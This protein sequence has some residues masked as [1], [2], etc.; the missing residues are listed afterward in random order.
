M[1]KV[2]SCFVLLS[3]VLTA[4]PSDNAAFQK[5][6]RGEYAKSYPLLL[7][8]SQKN[9][10]EALY[11]LA[12][13]KLYGYGERK[14]LAKGL[15]YMHLAADKNNLRAQMYLGAYYLN[16]KNNLKEAL[17]WLKKAANQGDASAQLFTG[18]CYLYGLD[19]KKNTDV[20]RK[21]FIMA[22]KNDVAMA[23]YELGQIFL[24]SRYARDRKMGRI[25][26][27]KARENNF[28]G[29][30]IVSHQEDNDADKNSS[31]QT[32][33]KLLSEAGIAI[34]N[35]KRLASTGNEK[36]EMPVYKPLSKSQ[37]IKPN[38][39]LITLNNFPIQPV[40]VQ[41]NKIAYL[42]HSLRINT[43]NVKD[44]LP[45]P[46][47]YNQ[48]QLR[49]LIREVNFGH[50]PAM[51]KLGLI[52][53]NGDNGLPRDHSKALSL[54]YNAA[55][56]NYRD[57]EYAVGLYA[58]NGWGMNKSLPHAM[59]WLRKAALHGSPRAQFLLG[60]IY[61]N[62]VSD[63]KP[64]QYVEKESSR[65]KAMYSLAAQNG[66]PGA[67]VRLA[68]MYASG[69]F[70][71]SADVSTQKKDL[72]IAFKLYRAA[73]KAHVQSA[74]IN[75][76]Y[77][78]ASHKVSSNNQAY[79]Y[80]VARKY[81]D[82]GNQNAKLLL[83]I[84]YSKG[85]GVAQNN[86]KAIEITESIVRDDVDNP[87][88]N[89]ILGTLY[90]QEHNQPKQSIKY[91]EKAAQQGSLFAS[92]NLAIIA[93][94]NGASED[95]FITLLRKS[96]NENFDDAS[97]LIADHYL[98][99][100]SLE[101]G[102]KVAARIYQS[103]AER[104]NATAQ[105]KLAYMYQH[106]IYY[107]K[108]PKAA[109]NWYRKSAQNGN[110]IAQYQLGEMFQFGLGVKR[111]I[112]TAMKYYKK[113]AEQNFAPAMVALGYIMQVDKL[114]YSDAKLWYQKAVALNNQQARQNLALINKYN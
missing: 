78:Y 85:V 56:H 18:L 4:Y 93:K 20:A 67:Q 111:N 87:I 55:K 94:K 104:H 63:G 114:K 81:A 24:K 96:A 44:L 73:A 107:T 39:Q 36:T 22:A 59:Y 106:G 80:S 91:L 101:G 19:T 105:L 5:Y 38:Y 82:M 76:A 34:A 10:A 31:L 112:H 43:Q 113:A 25:W 37:I 42:N 23:Q 30:G 7:E 14:N 98:Q 83:G 33:K 71:P 79:A 50:V 57:A 29:N 8:L 97:L 47:T 84:L 92:Y 88:A 77:F 40:I 13:I 90:Y 27:A 109:F 89:F 95:R 41:V 74:E 102:A 49:R 100:A 69:V 70:N 6:Y 86:Q 1:K 108:D 60:Y 99:Q 46:E 54:F 62:G 66:I 75:L 58:L 2:I 103:L 15:E 26:V 64:D 51:Y 16:D 35:P 61:E 48:D 9:N 65:A 52:Y 21:Y 68:Q 72:K 28:H 53:A 110:A 12:N 45:N 3:T 32:I 17:K 11:L